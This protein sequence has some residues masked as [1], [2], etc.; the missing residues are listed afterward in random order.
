MELA[1]LKNSTLCYKLEID[2]SAL[3]GSWLGSS[4]FPIHKLSTWNSHRTALSPTS[5]HSAANKQCS[6]LFLTLLLQLKLQPDCC[7]GELSSQPA[8]RVGAK[9]PK[10][11]LTSLVSQ[12]GPGELIQQLSEIQGGRSTGNFPSCS[13][14]YILSADDTR[15]HRK[16]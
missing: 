6:H 14:S 1:Q 13:R 12:Q 5:F 10:H 3:F 11:Q 9:Q 4:S 7:P 2:I 15:L 8:G 16:H